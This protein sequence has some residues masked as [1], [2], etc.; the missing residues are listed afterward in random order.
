M[1]QKLD[2]QLVERYSKIFRDRHEKS[3]KHTLMP[4]GFACGDGWYD[5]IDHL[6]ETLDEENPEVVAFQVKEKFG[7]LRFYVNGATDR[8]YQLINAAEYA[9]LCICEWCGRAGSIKGASGWMR[10]LCKKHRAL[11]KKGWRPWRRWYNR[12]FFMRWSWYRSKI[13]SMIRGYGLLSAR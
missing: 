2:Q 5:L 10:T 8:G 11:E 12:H 1:K 7:G 4:F 9:S 13:L 6:C 3:V